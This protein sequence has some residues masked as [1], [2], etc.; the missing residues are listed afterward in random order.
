MAVCMFAYVFVRMS[1]SLYV[2]VWVCEIV[3][4]RPLIHKIIC[5][6]MCTHAQLNI[7]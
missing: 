1:V 5:M 6:R 4:V 2:S 3:F 7:F